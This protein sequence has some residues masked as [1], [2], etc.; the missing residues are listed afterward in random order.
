MASLARIY[1]ST[2]DFDSN[3]LPSVA[4]LSQIRISLG[5]ARRSEFNAVLCSDDACLQ[6]F[7]A[8]RQKQ[9]TT[10]QESQRRYQALAA[11][12][13]Q[14]DLSE[15]FNQ[16]LAN[17]TPLSERVM[18]LVKEG[19]HDEATLQMRNVSGPA[20]DHVVAIV[21]QD[22]ARHL[23][24]AEVATRQAETLYG[25]VRALALMLIFVI[26]VASLL[27]G[28]LMT[29]AICRPLQR[30][31]EI[32]GCVADKDLTHTLSHDSEDELGQ[33][34]ISLNNTIEAI[35][36][37]LTSVTSSSDSLAAATLSLTRNAAK[38][39][40]DAQELSKQAQ[41]VAAT[42]E[43]MTATISEI[44]ENA[45][46]A[47]EA[48]RN[49]AR[50]AE[51]GGQ[52]MDESSHTMSRIATSTA[53][54]CEKITALGER[55]NQISKVVTVIHEISEQTNLLAL[56]A[57]IES[58]RAGEHGRGF[59]VVSGEV[60]RLAERATQSAKEIAAMI[61]SIQTEMAE[62]TS[63]VEAGR[64][65]VDHGIHRISEARNAIEALIGLANNSEKMITM[66]ATAAHEQSSASGEISQTI[67]K[68]AQIAGNSAAASDQTA[69]SCTSLEELAAGMNML[70]SE[71]RLARNSS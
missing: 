46:C 19:K 37:V 51:L 31:T 49:S 10:M 3:W 23:S 56:N 70:V 5:D 64:A 30:A 58:A 34:A 65:D 43:E 35:S 33:M 32:L 7:I 13:G 60:R 24:G 18:E 54:I 9:L 20:Y 21:A 16:G 38:S 2:K 12:Q 71:F 62:V 42:S 15:A 1:S 4:E 26:L 50:G 14:M 25:R 44:S 41:Q 11:A 40:K 69:I 52:A 47:A 67:A 53:A 8:T 45:E 48:S 39:S 55:S 6:R 61:H 28:R 36:G 63:M 29:T 68:I 17:Y 27:I 59:A 22:I 66:I 57:A